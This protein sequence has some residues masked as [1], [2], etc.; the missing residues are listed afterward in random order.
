MLSKAPNF[1]VCG[2]LKLYNVLF[3]TPSE[4]EKTFILLKREHDVEGAIVYSCSF[5]LLFIAVFRYVIFEVS[6]AHF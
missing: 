4:H 2:L 6:G 3:V 1:T 5:F